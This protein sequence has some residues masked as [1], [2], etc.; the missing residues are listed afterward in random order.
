MDE[1]QKTVNAETEKIGKEE[2]DTKIIAD[3]AQ[4]LTLTLTLC[5]TRAGGPR[6]GLTL[7]L[8]KPHA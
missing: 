4:A 1:Q 7:T 3:D 8:C 5:L 6:Q 2:A